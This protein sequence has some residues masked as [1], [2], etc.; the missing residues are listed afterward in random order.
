MSQALQDAMSASQRGAIFG[1]AKAAGLDNDALHDVVRRVTGK[2]SISDLTRGG[3]IRVI[4]TLKALTGQAPGRPALDSRVG[5]MT[6]AQ[7]RKILALC[8][9]LGWVTEA[10]EVDDDR[11][12]GF[13]RVRFKIQARQWVD[14]RKAGMI[15]E[16]MKK[17]V[18]G[19]RGERKRKEQEAPYHGGGS[20]G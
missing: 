19:G 18:A 10:G 11:L 2:E 3:A 9:Q 12:K 5:W 6:P 14:A 1:V 7:E 17:M 16:A 8:R 13:L 15:I 20:D 4:D